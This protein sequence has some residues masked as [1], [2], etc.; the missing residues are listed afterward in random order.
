MTIIEGG[1]RRFELKEAFQNCR[2][3][4]ASADEI[5]T[6]NDKVLARPFHEKVLNKLR[7]ANHTL[8]Y[9]KEDFKFNSRY[10][11]FKDGRV[12]GYWQNT[13]YFKDIWDAL[14]EELIFN[15]LIYT[16]KVEEQIK[17][18]DNNIGIH[19]RL[20][21]Y[22][23][24]AEAYGGICTSEYYNGGIDYI[25]HLTGGKCTLFVFSD[26]IKEAKKIIGR[27]GVYYVEDDKAPC[28]YDMYLMSICNHNITANSTYSWWGAWLNKSK[29]K[30]VIHP[31]LWDRKHPEMGIHVSEWVRIRE[32]GEVV[33]K[34]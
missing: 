17:K 25:E 28:W 10:L 18:C 9:E 16:G 11:V 21:D 12:E 32:N 34:K 26:N 23:D 2:V 33:R 22:V 4:I 6:F 13:R 27:K 1:G 29:D 20:T 7:P 24:A 31:D 30:I 5:K 3:R 8:M 14:S 15:K 19:I